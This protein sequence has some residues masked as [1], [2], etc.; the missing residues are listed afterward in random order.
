MGMGRG[1]DEGKAN[2]AICL[3][4]SFIKKLEGGR[5]KKLKYMNH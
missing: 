3:T 5:E 1:K 2:K 4:P